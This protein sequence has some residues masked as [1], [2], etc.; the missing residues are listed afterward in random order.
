[1]LGTGEIAM[2]RKRKIK[3]LHLTLLILMIGILIYAWSQ[4][5]AGEGAY[6]SGEVMQLSD[7]WI[8]NEDRQ[9]SI[10]FQ[11][12][13]EGFRNQSMKISRVLEQV[14]EA[15]SLVIYTRHT[16]LEVYIEEEC[17]FTYGKEL[18]LF[19]VPPVNWNVIPMK[20]EY[21]GKKLQLVYYSE[22]KKYRG[23]VDTIY[24]GDKTAILSEIMK[25]NL[26]TMICAILILGISLVIV[27][28]RIVIGKRSVSSQVLY[29]AVFGF[30]VATWV[31][32]DIRIP[33]FVLGKVEFFNVVVF[34]LLMILP[35]PFILFYNN[36]SWKDGYEIDWI[37]I[38]PGV[39]FILCNLCQILKV[40]DIS[41]TV[42]LSH[43]T[44]VVSFIILGYMNFRYRKR[45]TEEKKL[46]METIGF[47][48]LVITVIIDLIRYHFLKGDLGFSYI[49]LLAYIICLMMQISEGIFSNMMKGKKAAL[50]EELAY[51]DKM[52]GLWNR[53]AY[54]EHLNKLLDLGV[55]HTVGYG[56]FAFDLNNLKKINDRYGHDR[57]DQYIRDN[58]E[59]LSREMEEIGRVYRTGGDEFVCIFDPS[60]REK[61]QN[62]ADRLEEQVRKGRDARINFSFGFAICELNIDKSFEDTIRRAD[63]AM[64]AYKRRHKAER[65][66]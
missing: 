50:Y 54:Q 19:T 40:A 34:E 30:L 15:D 28:L 31:M 60:V 10:P 66:E 48:I 45:N 36:F 56:V 11:L 41:Q 5:K 38:I 22:A 26:V 29:L 62:C 58:A 59:Y 14:D 16:A 53:T 46:S 37:S 20:S 6:C 21:S 64:Y 55:E 23:H 44:I 52:T 35:I 12:E 27:M 65:I 51:H 7:G 42:T 1:V 49:G 18:K 39:N 3:I 8:L 47:V 4:D 9:I 17:I 13:G 43:L 24:L 32:I 25:Y 63:S 57:G 61:A 2:S 33:Q